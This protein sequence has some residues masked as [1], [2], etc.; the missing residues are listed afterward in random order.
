MKRHLASL[1]LV[2]MGVVVTVALI[3][4]GCSSSPSASSSCTSGS[5]VACTC[6][7]GQSGT[8]ACGV[9]G[10]TCGEG[11]GGTESEDADLPGDA[12]HRDDQAAPV[13]TY[14]ACALKGSFGWP[15]TLDAS[16]PDPLE[17]TDPIFPDCFAGAQGGR[18]T[19]LCGDAGFAGCPIVAADAG[20]V[21]SDC[22]AR[23]YCK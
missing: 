21:P 23:G 10:C 4:V 12:T 22:N 15:C 7:G 9:A 6:A 17:C 13:I 18:C 2:S 11:D 3:A 14:G 20:C 1:L 5:T 19:V 8:Q 16:G